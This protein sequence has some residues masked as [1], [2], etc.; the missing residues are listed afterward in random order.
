MSLRW[1]SLI[2][3]AG[4]IYFAFGQTLHGNLISAPD[5]TIIRIGRDIGEAIS[6][7]ASYIKEALWS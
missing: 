2:V 7:T 3:C 5:E 1:I 4:T 6:N